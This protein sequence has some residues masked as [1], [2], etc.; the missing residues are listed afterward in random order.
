[1]DSFHLTKY[2]SMRHFTFTSRIFT[3]VAFKNK[4]GCVYEHYNTHIHAKELKTA[5]IALSVADNE[6]LFNK[7]NI[8]IT[9]QENHRKKGPIYKEELGPDAKIVYIAEPTYIKRIFR[10]GIQYFIK[11]NITQTL[12]N[13]CMKFFIYFKLMQYNFTDCRIQV[14]QTCYSECM[15]SL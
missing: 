15:D 4:I 2:S 13:I 1:M 11:I 6:D 3:N 10:E 9:N 8:H 14:S 7:R 12:N 5:A